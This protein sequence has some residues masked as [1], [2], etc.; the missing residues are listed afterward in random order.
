MS[1]SKTCKWCGGEFNSISASGSTQF[2]SKKCLNADKE[3]RQKEKSS[4]PSSGKSI[5]GTLF[6]L[7]FKK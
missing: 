6:S 2:C 1:M 7:I 4:K 3:F 5:L